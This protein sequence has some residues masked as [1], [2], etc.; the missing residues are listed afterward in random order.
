M[1]GSNGRGRWQQQ[2]QCSSSSGR[3]E[4]GETCGNFHTVDHAATRNE[5]REHIHQRQVKEPPMTTV[6]IS[7]RREDSRWVSGRIYDALVRRY[8]TANV[9]KDV[10]TIPLGVDFR[11]YL[12]GEV[13]RCDV[14][15]VL[16]GPR[17]LSASDEAG[18]RR[19][20]DP[21]D[22]TRVET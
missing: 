11:D 19:L 13:S 14:M 15:L 3:N 10:Y 7:Y 21:G 9:F 5:P 2:R 4:A 8:G 1:H 6:F 22:F 17:W 18:Q 16:I 12:G 20:D